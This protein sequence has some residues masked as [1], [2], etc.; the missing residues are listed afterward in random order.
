M[1]ESVEKVLGFFSAL[2]RAVPALL[3]AAQAE[4]DEIR[5]TNPAYLVRPHGIFVG[6]KM[7]EREESGIL[8][9]QFEPYNGEGGG[10]GAPYRAVVPPEIIATAAMTAGL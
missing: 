8:F 9:A 6:F 5:K 3:A 2:E 1:A 7:G 10:Y 4:A